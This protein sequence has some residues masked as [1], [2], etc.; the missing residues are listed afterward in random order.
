MMMISVHYF[1]RRRFPTRQG[2]FFKCFVL[3]GTINILLDIS[4]AFIVER[5]AVMPRALVLGIN[6]LFYISQLSLPIMLYYYSMFLAN[7]LKLKHIKALLV[8]VIPGAVTFVML[9]SNIKTAYFFYLDAEG[10]YRHGV[11][12]PYLYVSA[13]IYLI[14]SVGTVIERGARIRTIE[15]RTIISFNVIIVVAVV[16]QSKFPFLLLTGAATA[17]AITMTYFT[18]Q[19]GDELVDWLTGALNRRGFINYIEEQIRSERKYSVLAIDLDEIGS[20]NDLLG[21]DVGDETIVA[22]T[23]IFKECLCGGILFRMV[24]DEFVIVTHDEI[25][26]RTALSM[27][28]QRLSHPLK[29]MGIELR[30]SACM[31]CCYDTSF[32][33]DVADLMNLINATV[34]KAKAE[35]LGA[36]LETDSETVKSLNRQKEVER[37]LREAIDE[38]RIEVYL[39]PIYDAASGRYSSAEALARLSDSRLGSISPGE[40]IPLAER[41]GL[42]KQLGSIVLEKVC[43][44]L[45]DSKLCE[46]EGFGSIAVNLSVVECI[47]DTLAARVLSTIRRYGI[48]PGSIHF[49]ITETAATSSN[50][51]SDLMKTLGDEG[52][53]FLLD[54]FG[55]GY[56]NLERVLELSFCTIKLDRA[57]IVACESGNSKSIIVFQHIVGLARDLGIKTVAEGVENRRQVDFLANS[58]VDSY[59]G[60]FYACPMTMERGL[61]FFNDNMAQKAEEAKK[62]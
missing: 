4:S 46:A 20:V 28:Q 38:G 60:F 8:G 18:L 11:L 17:L 27:V 34:I 5:A 31:C 39:Q 25:D 12:F 50:R 7:R 36:L 61:A 40:F 45:H 47:D 16:I 49:E 22:A 19:N 33:T 58:G 14:L 55:M 30:V 62:I 24:G 35:G 51:L 1:V 56:S 53:R 43:I 57:L 59:Q 23:E 32:I 13:A 42:I 9:L 3:M 41:T 21:V 54:D 10:I 37:A 48:D 26:C 29:V 44:F 15:Q 52:I 6:Y 2:T